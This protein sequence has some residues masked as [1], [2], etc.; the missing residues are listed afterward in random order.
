MVRDSRVTVTYLARHL[1]IGQRSLLT[2]ARG[3]NTEG[4]TLEHLR[5]YKVM[6]PPP[7][8][9][10]KWEDIERQYASLRAIASDHL[11]GSTSLFDSLAQ[12]AFRGDI[13]S[14]SSD[15]LEETTESSRHMAN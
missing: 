14:L 1:R 11:S 7:H 15:Q 12:R 10:N 8:M 6:V 2:K 13:Q 9:V 4:L 5:D 3:A